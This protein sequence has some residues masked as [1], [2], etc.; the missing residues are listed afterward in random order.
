MRVRP[1]IIASATIFTLGL[2]ISAAIAA[3]TDEDAP[4]VGFDRAVHFKVGGPVDP[5]GSMPMR[6][7]WQM[8]DLSGICY[9]SGQTWNDDDSGPDVVA[10]PLKYGVDVGS[11]QDKGTVGIQMTLRDCSPAKN[12]R[13][14]TQTFQRNAGQ[15]DQSATFTGT[16]KTSSCTCFAGGTDRNSTV[17]G[18]TAEFKYSGNSVALIA[19]RAPGRGKA[20]ML[21]DGIDRGT[22][23]FSNPASLNRQVVWTWYQDTTAVH[24]LTIKVLSGRV[25]VDAFVSD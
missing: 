21:V 24:T 25:D 14:V 19:P 5:W 22:V 6:I 13:T 15:D 2:G 7:S 18:D 12:E 11:L 3:P 16:W 20:Q 1:A 8:S 10:P 4:N 9:Q 17:V 23:D